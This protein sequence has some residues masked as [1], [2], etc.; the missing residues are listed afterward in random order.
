MTCTNKFGKNDSRTQLAIGLLLHYKQH[1]QRIQCDRKISYQSAP[2]S[3]QQIKELEV[4]LNLIAERER[5][6]RSID[7]AI[8]GVSL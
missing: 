1:D 2:L 6:E 5:L 4:V 8:K 3:A 7:L